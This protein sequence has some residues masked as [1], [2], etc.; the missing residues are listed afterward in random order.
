MSQLGLYLELTKPRIITMILVTTALGFF[1]GSPGELSLWRM[2]WTLVGT[3]LAAGGAGTLNHYLERDVDAMM[4]RTQTRPLPTGGLRAGPTLSFGFGLIIVGQVVLVVG[5]NLLTAWLALLT[6]FLYVVIYTPMKRMTWL[7]TSMGAIPGAL[8]PVGGWTAASGE[9]EWGAWALFAILFTW[10]HPHFFAIAWLFRDDYR[11]AGFQML[12]CVEEEGYPRTCRQ[13]IGFS[14]LLLVASMLPAY[15]GISGI[16]YTVGAIL[17]GLGMLAAS[18]SLVRVRDQYQARR[19]LR[20]SV[21]YLPLLFLL[22]V[23][24]VSL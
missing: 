12:P 3:A 21:I 14:I 2:L 17:L 11:S 7:N 8:P 4:R 15:L 20:A 18:V 24:D 5:T 6:A 1:L 22:T 10:Q 23:I 13:I 9:L 19:L 16:V